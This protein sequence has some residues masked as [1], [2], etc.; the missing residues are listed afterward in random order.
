MYSSETFFYPLNNT[1]GL[2]VPSKTLPSL[3]HVMSGLGLPFTPQV[4]LTSFPSFL[5]TMESRCAGL[6]FGFQLGDES[7]K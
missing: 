5:V 3:Y 4:N 2:F 1:F 6:D 7:E